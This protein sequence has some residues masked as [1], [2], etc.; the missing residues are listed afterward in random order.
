MG[1]IPHFP[2]QGSQSVCVCIRLLDLQEGTQTQMAG[3]PWARFFF[4][5][6]AHLNFGPCLEAA[7]YDGSSACSASTAAKPLA[8]CDVSEPEGH[9][10]CATKRL[11]S[12]VQAGTREVGC[13]ELAGFSSTACGACS[14]Q[15]CRLEG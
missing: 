10:I 14:S 1:C 6:Q 4:G 15:C 12:V 7:R 9:A 3:M 8:T 11:G 2:V 5:P 13:A